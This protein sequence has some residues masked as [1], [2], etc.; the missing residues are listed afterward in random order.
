MFGFIKTARNSLSQQPQEVQDG[1]TAA[2]EVTGTYAGVY[3][4][5]L[6]LQKVV[7][8][9]VWRKVGLE[10][11]IMRYWNPRALPPSAYSRFRHLA[12]MGVILGTCGGS[13]GYVLSEDRRTTMVS[14]YRSRHNIC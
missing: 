1:V 9:R 3:L 14:L 4:T 11:S 8:D 7:F 10:G 12:V 13:L 5:S 6:S 2:V